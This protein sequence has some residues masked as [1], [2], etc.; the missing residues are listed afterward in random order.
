M[1]GIP[2]V[3]QQRLRGRRISSKFWD[4]TVRIFQSIY[5]AKGKNMGSRIA[6]ETLPYIPHDYQWL[7]Q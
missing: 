1:A 3:E 2:A 4:G 7:E 6:T 5:I